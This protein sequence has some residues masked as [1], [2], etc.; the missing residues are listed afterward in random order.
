M[1]DLEEEV[2]LLTAENDMLEQDITALNKRLNVAE[3]CLKT[4][5]SEGYKLKAQ[6]NNQKWRQALL[7][8]KMKDVNS[9]LIVK[10]V[11]V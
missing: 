4:L 1:T 10:Q 6:H 5:V 3:K 2:E 7:T 9:N 8:Q 11:S